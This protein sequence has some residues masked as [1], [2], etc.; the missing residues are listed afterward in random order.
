MVDRCIRLNK[1][2]LRQSFQS[3]V[4]AADNA[5]RNAAGKPEWVA[6]CEYFFPDLNLVAVADFYRRQWTSCID[7]QDGKISSATGAKQLALVGRAIGECD[8]DFVG[9]H[10]NMPVRDNE[11]TGVND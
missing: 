9:I 5:G 6:D 8:V 3:A 10:N 4:D 7:F 11:A 2:V 1:L